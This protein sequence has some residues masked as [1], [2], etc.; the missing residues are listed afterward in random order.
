[1]ANEILNEAFVV[2]KQ[3]NQNGKNI[4]FIDPSKPENSETFKYKDIFKN[5]GARWHDAK[6]FGGKQSFWFWYIGETEDQWRKVY[7]G[8]IEPALK[9][10]HKLEGAPEEESATALAGSLEA[11]I[12]QV[13]A[14]PTTND[15]T[16][17][18]ELTAEEKK[19]IIAKLGQFKETLVNLDNDEEFKKTMQIILSFKN[20]QGH[21][22]SF[23]NTILIMIQNPNARLVKSEINWNKFNRTIIDK[24][25][26]MV[27]RSPSKSALRPYSKIEREKITSDFLKSIGKTNYSELGPG[28]RERLSIM[29]RGAFNGQ[30]FDYTFV[31]DVSNTKQIEGR[32]NYL[33]DYEKRK[34]IKWFEENM[35]SEEVRPI[36]QALLDFGKENDI[37]IEL[38]DDLDGAN[39]VSSGGLVRIL[40]NNGNDVGLTK[41]LAHEI[42]HELLHQNYLKN[43]N[44]KYAQYFVGRPEGRDA[45]E[46]QAEL[47]AWMVLGAFD[48]DL[49]TTSLNYAAIWGA[50]KDAMIRVFDTVSS[51]VS[52][53]VEYISRKTK[54]PVNAAQNEVEGG[55]RIVS[56]MDV[57]RFVGAEKDY[58]DVLN[59][60]QFR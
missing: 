26:R 33:G 49:K 52:M 56:P 55:G 41:T 11:L 17:D 35:I 42:S 16:N 27:V 44:S 5:H 31:Y 23:M 54:K 59:K 37:R 45:V 50:D 29:L 30:S 2:S 32:E 53:L 6:K 60:N 14:T 40:K 22:Y 36:Y 43:R 38:V 8:F 47:S 9:E 10:V 18:T 28:E 13:Q 39:G 3:I 20:A 15:P 24:R 51:V 46:Q 1:M 25:N 34:E 19:A 57:A 58:Q 4:A 7:K 21:S 12:G 48:F